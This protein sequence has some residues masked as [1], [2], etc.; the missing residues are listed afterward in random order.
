MEATE[1]KCG[2]IAVDT[3]H[4]FPIIKKWLYSERE[5]FLRELVSNAVDAVTAVAVTP[6][7][8]AFFSSMEV[9]SLASAS[10][11]KA[12]TSIALSASTVEALFIEERIASYALEYSA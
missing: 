6:I 8:V 12:S 7:T 10:A 9:T 11:F 2:G 3:E 4:I 1:K 5:I